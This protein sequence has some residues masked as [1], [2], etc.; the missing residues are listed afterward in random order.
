M[1]KNRMEVREEDDIFSPRLRIIIGITMIILGIVSAIVT[2]KYVIP[3][4]SIFL[5]GSGLALIFWKRWKYMIHS[6]I[7]RNV[8]REIK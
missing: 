4:G 5:I 8:N 7:L 3:I 2:Y 1:R 6:I